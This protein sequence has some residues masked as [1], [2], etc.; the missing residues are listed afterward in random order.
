MRLDHWSIA[1]A[2][3]LGPFAFSERFGAMRQEVVEQP[4]INGSYNGDAD[5]DQ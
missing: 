3:P 4:M 2:W 1:P 5:Y